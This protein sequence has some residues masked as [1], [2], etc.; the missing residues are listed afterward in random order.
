[1]KSLLKLTLSIFGLFVLILIAVKFLNLFTVEQLKG[2]LQQANDLSPLYVGSIVIA[3][4]VIDLFI[5]V[6]TLMIII[7]AGYFLG[8]TTGVIASL[9]GLILAGTGGH[10]LGRLFGSKIL[11]FIIRSE[12]ERTEARQSFS[13]HGFVMILLSRA[14]PILPEVTS[15]LSGM[16]RMPFLKFFSAW[17][18]SNI[19]YVMIASYAGSISSIDD[20]M[21]AVFVSIGLAIILWLGWFI[22]HR[23]HKNTA[24]VRK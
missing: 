16:A 23:I 5:S 11:N 9:I 18:L 7:L 22:F 17:L 10:I 21:P 20:S 4:L 3:L 19:P 15:C 24:A 1:M 2:W 6:P 8:Y 12:P 14:L 13:E